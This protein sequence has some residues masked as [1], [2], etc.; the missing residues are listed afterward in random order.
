[1]IRFFFVVLFWVHS[2]VLAF[3]QTCA[4]PGN[5]SELS[6]VLGQGVNSYRAS[7]GL[8]AIAADRA[9]A[10]AAERH[11]CDLART[12]QMTHRG[13]DGSSSMSRAQ[14]AGFRPCLV[15]ENLAWGFPDPNR[16]VQGWAGSPAH[17][18]NMLLDR[19]TH[20]GAAV[21]QGPDGPLWVMVY[22]QK[23]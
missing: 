3:A 11:A 21:A 13:S 16:I 23:C 20:Y 22:A 1:M 5:A 6:A 9:L 4:T 7:Q 15:A 18:T 2:P 14:R 19:I 10:Q 12:G 8:P 17:R